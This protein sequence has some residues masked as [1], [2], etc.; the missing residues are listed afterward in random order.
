[1]KYSMKFVK[2]SAPEIIT[3]V[4]ILTLYIG[5]VAAIVNYFMQQ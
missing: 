5:T 4:F 1:M 2:S 3:V